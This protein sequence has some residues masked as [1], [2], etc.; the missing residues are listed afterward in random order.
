[1]HRD[2]KPANVLL[3]ADG[4]PKVTD[5]GLARHFEVRRLADAD[6]HPDGDSQLHGPRA[7]R[8]RN[9]GTIGPAVDIYALGAILYEMLTGRPPFRAETAAETEQQ[10]VHEE[11][12]SAVAV[13]HEGAARPGDD[14]PEVPAQG[15]GAALRQRRGAGR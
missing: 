2:L 6:R 12:V 9:A 1:M 10:V 13:E 11:P 4:M 14:L 8:G 15:A 3:T 7:G 5:F